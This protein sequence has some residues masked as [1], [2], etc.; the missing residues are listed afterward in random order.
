MRS[1]HNIVFCG[2]WIR[3]CFRVVQGPT[4]KTSKV[5]LFHFRFS[6]SQKSHP[7]WIAL[8]IKPGHAFLSRLIDLTIG[9]KSPVRKIRLNQE[10]KKDLA[11]W[12][13]FL[14]KFNGKSFF[15]DC[16]WLSSNKLNLYTDAS[17][18]YVFG[19]VFGSH[20]CYGKWPA[21]R[22]YRNKTVLE[23]YPIVLSLHLWGNSMANKHMLFFTDNN[24]LVHV[25]NKINTFSTLSVRKQS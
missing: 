19:T 15:F 25:I 13:E 23:F 7:A 24:A 20:W 18:A 9:I 3:Y 5:Y 17:G 6:A 22:S 14:Q 12:L 16:N 1:C 4:R 8:F 21:N 11:L 10:V 2:N